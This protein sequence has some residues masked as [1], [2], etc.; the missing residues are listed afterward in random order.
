MPLIG[1]LVGALIQSYFARRME[2]NKQALT[3]K[4]QAYADYLKAFSESGY[5]SSNTKEERNLLHERAANAKN[6]IVIFG[7]D[8]VISKLSNFIKLGES[9]KTNESLK[10]FTEL[11]SAMRKDYLGS[12]FEVNIQSLTTIIIGPKNS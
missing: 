12:E 3:F 6:R 11:C 10:A 9:L 2:S 1:L 5:L 4:S 8:E 7:S